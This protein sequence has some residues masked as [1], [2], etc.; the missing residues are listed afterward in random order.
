[1]L[2]RHHE[3]IARIQVTHVEMHD[4]VLSTGIDPTKVHKIPIRV[5]PAYLSRKR[6]SLAQPRGL[7]ST[8]HSRLSLS[9]RSRKMAWVGRTD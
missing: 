9:A 8:C 2:R 1:M 4:L 7:L 6:S 3:K 5:N